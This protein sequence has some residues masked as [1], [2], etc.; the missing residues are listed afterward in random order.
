[1]FN[2]QKVEW[3]GL[4]HEEV[5]PIREFA[6]YAQQPS[7]QFADT[8][9][10]MDNSFKA[11]VC[12]DVKELTY[13]ISY[14]RLVEQPYL[15]DVTNKGWVDYAKDSYQSLKSRIE[16]KGKRYEAFKKGDLSMYL[17]DVYTNPEFEKE[18][19]ESSTLVNFQGARKDV[20]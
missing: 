3:R 15:I 4:I 8:E 2:R 13:F 6:T 18:R 11:K 19:F 9:K 17:E 7:F 12:N 10:D 20:L 1:M 16:A 14:L 5:H